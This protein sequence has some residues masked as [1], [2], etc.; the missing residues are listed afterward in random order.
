MKSLKE[1]LE[2]ASKQNKRIKEVSEDWFIER[3]YIK[4]EAFGWERMEILER[5][6]LNPNAKGVP[7]EL[8]DGTEYK[9]DG[10]KKKVFGNFNQEEETTGHFVKTGK[11]EWAP[12]QNYLLYRQFKKQEYENYLKQKF[13][14]GV[15]TPPIEL[16]GY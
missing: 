10:Y 15:N 13:A 4:T 6:G 2:K 11:K 5:F 3:G 12:T 14:Q 1:L 8:I 7:H 16:F 9:K